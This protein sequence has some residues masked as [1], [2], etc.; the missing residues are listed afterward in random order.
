MFLARR[1]TCQFQ[2]PIVILQL[3]INYNNNKN[4]LSRLLYLGPVYMEVGDSTGGLPTK[5]G[6]L[7]YLGSLTSM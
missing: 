2:L 3:V 6:Y 5:V 4:K 7:T 1:A